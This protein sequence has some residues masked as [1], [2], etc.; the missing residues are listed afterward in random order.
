[1]KLEPGK[2]CPLIQKDCIGLQCN[3]FTQ[4]RGSNPQSGAEVD[5]WSC[6]ITWLPLLLINTALEARQGAAATESLRNE[7][8]VASDQARLQQAALANLP[9]MRQAIEMNQG[10]K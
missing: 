5:E 9:S 7:V 4:V 2:F 6:A 1:M 3:W 10:A 8:V